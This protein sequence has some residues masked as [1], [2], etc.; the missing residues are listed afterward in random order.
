MH[1]SITDKQ[2]RPIQL[3]SGIKSK[4]NSRSLGHRA[5]SLVPETRRLDRIAHPPFSQSA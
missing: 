5:C 3:V 4:I 2:S 1:R